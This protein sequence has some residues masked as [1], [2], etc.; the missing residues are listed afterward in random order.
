MTAPVAS[1]SR[2][3]VRCGAFG[4]VLASGAVWLLAASA[5]TP[6]VQ[7]SAPR[8]ADSNNAAAAD[9]AAPAASVR[10]P[11]GTPQTLPTSEAL[12]D[13]LR[14]KEVIELQFA[15]PLADQKQLRDS[16]SIK[17]NTKDFRLAWGEG[18]G[19]DRG[20][21]EAHLKATPEN[22]RLLLALQ[23]E[24]TPRGYLLDTRRVRVWSYEADPQQREQAVKL[25]PEVL[26]AVKNAIEQAV[27]E[28]EC[29]LLLGN[30]TSGTPVAVDY[31]L[32]RTK[33]RGGVRFYNLTLP[34]IG[35]AL[36][37]DQELHL[38]RL[39]LL[40]TQ[41]FI[42]DRDGNPEEVARLRDAARKAFAASV[43]PLLKL[44]PD[45][46]IWSSRRRDE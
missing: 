35:G 15:G 46:Q 10:R 1:I 34:T 18:G 43:E 24:L 27:P 38:P 25:I 19:T 8:A 2:S 3:S 42:G 30:K 22:V 33:A 13:W 12:E 4:A 16:I 29:K 37:P 41:T 17:G 11:P 9:K 39:G 23:A 20:F 6:T 45:A 44:E 7:D 32:P 40:V 31:A 14:G 36:V 21:V 5:Q 28:A 26:T